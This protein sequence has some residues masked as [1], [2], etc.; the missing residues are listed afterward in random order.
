MITRLLRLLSVGIAAASLFAVHPARAQTIGA[1]F[2]GVWSSESC[3]PYPGGPFVRR[4]ILI[5]GNRFSRVIT[6]FT[7]G[8]CSIPTLR[9]RVEGEFVFRGLSPIIPTPGVYNIEL[10]WE[11][12]FLRPE[13][14]N[15][16]DFLNSHRP[17]LCGGAWSVG[18]EQDLESTAGCRKLGIDLRRPIIEYDITGRIDTR[19]FFG[20]RPQNGAQLY[21]VKDRP[22]SFGAPLLKTNEVLEPT[23]APTPVPTKQPL[24]PKTG[25]G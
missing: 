18:A 3:E 6:A 5:E 25:N 21:S 1:D 17:G 4:E 24:L 10:R 13:R 23:L 22:I 8:R 14:T 7:D 11:R 15:E 9:M 12:V 16:A 20:T 2:G 19:I